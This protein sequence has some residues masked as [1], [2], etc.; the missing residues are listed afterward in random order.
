MKF[1][2]EEIS[3]SATFKR[4][5]DNREEINERIEKLIEQWEKEDDEKCIIE[6][7]IKRNG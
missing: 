3:L 1:F 2:D 5:Y 6:Y 7:K 4:I